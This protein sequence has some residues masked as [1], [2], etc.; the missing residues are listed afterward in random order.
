MNAILMKP[1]KFFAVLSNREK[2]RRFSLSQ[3]ISRS[4]ILRSLYKSLSNS[5][6]RASRSWL[7]CVGITGLMSRSIKYSSIQ[8]AR[9]PLSPATAR[10]Q[11]A[12]LPFRSQRLASAP[13]M[14][15]SKTVDSCACPGVRWKWKGC[16][17]LSQRIWIFVEKPP[18]ERPNA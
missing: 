8:S 14:R 16:P 9:Y 1:P 13:S 2:I 12:G 4:T 11:A 18:R 7:S 17:S 15:L 10:G 3:P 6:G 5:T